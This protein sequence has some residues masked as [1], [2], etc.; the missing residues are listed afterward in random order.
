VGVIEATKT[1]IRIPDPRLR[2]QEMVILRMGLSSMWYHGKCFRCPLGSLSGR[3]KGCLKCAMN[4]NGFL[5][6]MR[7]HEKAGRSLPGNSLAA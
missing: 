7:Y 5:L 3:R 6:E 2:F 4:G 1:P